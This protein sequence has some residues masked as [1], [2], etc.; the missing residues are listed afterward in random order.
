[1]SYYGNSETGIGYIVVSHIFISVAAGVIMVCDAVAILAAVPNHD[2]AVCLAV[3]GLFDNIGGAIG[4]TIASTV[5]Q[6]IFRRKLM[7]F[8]PIEELPNV[9]K[10]YADLST[11]LS[12]PI[13]SEAR[14]AIQHAY[15]DTQGKL[16]AIAMAVWAGGFM[17]VVMWRNINVININQGR[18]CK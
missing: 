15:E 10:I 8:V 12:Y 18:S 7:E 17:A 6:S 14:I 3:L 4:L 13:G 11:Q 2:A 9:V 5:W 1:M 16:L